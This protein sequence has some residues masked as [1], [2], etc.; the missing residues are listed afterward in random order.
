MRVTG[1]DSGLFASCWAVSMA[2]R[3]RPPTAPS[4]MPAHAAQASAQPCRRGPAA[5][6]K[7]APP[8]AGTRVTPPCRR[9]AARQFQPPAGAA[10][11]PAY[12]M[13]AASPA[14]RSPAMAAT[15]G[16]MP[17]A[18]TTAA[19]SRSRA[20]S[21]PSARPGGM[22]QRPCRRG[23]PRDQRRAGADRPRQLGRPRHP[24]RLG[25]A[26]CQRGRCLRQNDWTAV[27]VQVGHDASS[28]RPHLS[29]PTAS[30]TTARTSGQRP[31]YAAA[32]RCRR[33]LRF[34]QLAEMPDSAGFAAQPVPSSRRAWTAV[35]QGRATPPPLRADGPLA[36]ISAAL[37]PRASMAGL[38]P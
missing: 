13:P 38:P 33:S 18:A 10:A 28:Y 17:P 16:A 9:P 15:G 23:Q 32:S 24:P 20:R 36:A 25:H 1:D 14:W 31:V 26:Q 30:S 37:A 4:R 34:E 2:A 8:R 35:A 5:A 7:Q 6:A 27:R 21:W 19:T 12:P 22:S 29:R 3:G 11:S